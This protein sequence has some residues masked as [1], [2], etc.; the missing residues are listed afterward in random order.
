MAYWNSVWNS[1]DDYQDLPRI[2]HFRQFQLFRHR[3]LLIDFQTS[4]QRTFWQSDPSPSHR[5][6]LDQRALLDS[7]LQ[8]IELPSQ[9]C[10]F[11]SLPSHFLFLSSCC[12]VRHRKCKA[13]WLHLYLLQAC[14]WNFWAWPS[15]CTYF[16]SYSFLVKVF[17]CFPL[18]LMMH[19]SCH[20]SE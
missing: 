10:H 6:W 2:L 13:H 12:L 16:C 7:L 4:I 8:C 19:L 15:F 17:E 9:V 5:R 14:C 1:L 11:R 3:L 18:V 20:C